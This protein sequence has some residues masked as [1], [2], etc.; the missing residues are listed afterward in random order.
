MS[1]SSIAVIGAGI[2]GLAC[3]R[4]LADAGHSVAV[5]DKG[6]GL[7]GRLATRRVDGMAFD[8][9]AQYATARQMPFREMLDVLTDDG[10]AAPW[11]AVWAMLSEDGMTRCTPSESRWVGVPGMSSMIGPLADGLAVYRRTRIALLAHERE[12]GGW[13]LVDSDGHGHGPFARLVLAVP[14]PQAGDL[15]GS[16][17]ARFPDLAR[18]RFAPCWAAMIAFRA[19]LPLPFDAA[20]LDDPVLAQAARN[21]SKPQRRDGPDCWVLHAAPD[22]SRARLEWEP[23]TVAKAL[24]DRFLNLTGVAE[25]DAAVYVH[26]HRWRH[27]LVEEAAGRPY[28]H[29][30]SLGLGLAGDWCLGPRVELAFMSGHL[31]G[32]AMVADM[33]AAA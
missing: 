26:A 23:E 6:R 16:Y 15:L 32:E 3:A 24:L 29:D 30:P 28:L 1:H 11:H 7:G 21:S 13:V 2:A 19:P 25:A 18:V 20:R 8:H 22:W 10:S 9:G 31:L 33:A 5:F 4:R 27:A 14:A 17:A 12:S